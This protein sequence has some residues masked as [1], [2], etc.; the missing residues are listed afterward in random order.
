MSAI[1]LAVPIPEIAEV[2]DMRTGELIPSHV[3]IGSDYGKAMAL[4]MSLRQSIAEGSP[5]CACPLCGIPV[6]L[7]A[8]K[9]ARKFFFRHLM[10]DGRCAARTRGVLSEAEINARKY[11]GVKESRDH[12][13]MK[14]IVAESLRCDPRFSSV[15]IEAVMKNRDR[16]AWRKPDVQA[17]YE[18]IPV[19][20][21]IQ[22][23]TTFLRTIAERRVFYQREGGLLVWIFKTYDAER[24][25]LTQD[26][27]FYCNNRNIFLV[28]EATLEA[29]R[30]SGKLILDCRWAEPF[31]ADG[32]L[33]SRWS[34]RLVDFVDLTNDR[35]RQRVFFFDYD[36]AALAL[37]VG[38]G[39][40]LR[41]EFEMFWLSRRNHDP[42]DPEAWNRLRNKF[43]ARGIVLPIEPNW[44]GAPSHFLNS[45]YS[46]REGRSV[47]WRFSKLVDV[48]HRIADGHKKL[49]PAFCHALEVYDRMEQILLEDPEGTWRGKVESFRLLRE[50]NSPEYE[51][52]RRFDALVDFLFPEL[53]GGGHGP[54]RLGLN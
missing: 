34:G 29:S 41:Q 14:E 26:D 4:R 37:K 27:I 21:E 28:S 36:H 51:P 8:R 40:A 23:S 52:D 16:T 42:W 19:A 11:N 5:L 2:L 9:E 43:G 10:E 45:L 53:G 50:A 44:G 6:Y 13:R 7:V 32:R 35:E 47:G 18:G 31:I 33:G 54:A 20:F 49:L 30:A 15:K 46:A 22:L 39:Q 38:D 24:A 17:I 1:S 3:A 48:A 12:I 25:R